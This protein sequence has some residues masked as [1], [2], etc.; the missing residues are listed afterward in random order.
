MALNQKIRLQI[1]SALDDAGIKATAD[2]LEKLENKV[3]QAQ[4]T[5]QGLGKQM[6]AAFN[7]MGAVMS[8]ASGNVN[9]MIK[10]FVNLGLAVKGVT[11]SLGAMTGIFGGITLVVAGVKKLVDMF[12]GAKEEAEKTAK[13]TA[14]TFAKRTEEATKS[15]TVEYANQVKAIEDVCKKKNA[16]LD[17]NQKLIESEIRLAK[18]KEGASDAEIEAAIASSRAKNDA[19]KAANEVTMGTDVESVR[20]HY[21][22]SAKQELASINAK[23]VSRGE[24]ALKKTTKQRESIIDRERAAFM[25]DKRGNTGAGSANDEMWKMRLNSDS[26]QR[27]IGREMKKWI[28]S[29]KSSIWGDDWDTLH[30]LQAAANKNVKSIERDIEAAKADKERTDKLRLEAINIETLNQIKAEKEERK[31]MQE[32]LH[33]QRMADLKAETGALSAAK[34]RFDKEFALYKSADKGASQIEAEKQDEEARKQLTKDAARYGGKWRIDE[35]SRLYASGDEDAVK[36]T[37]SQWRKRKSFTPEVE[38]MVRAAAAKDNVKTMED[39]VDEIAENTKGLAE[40]VEELLS[41][42]GGD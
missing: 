9:G 27:K 13:A 19:A 38:A 8:V 35:L 26:M 30:T 14:E 6:S 39:R 21:L 41:M 15:L 5:A 16:E 40:K 29:N 10:S 32:D 4:S 7:P 23:I 37:L 17:V 2:Q 25:A 18:A 20:K 34:A 42:K 12:R 28:D 3:V 33:R 11:L 36:S 24:E 1:I 31:K 22:E